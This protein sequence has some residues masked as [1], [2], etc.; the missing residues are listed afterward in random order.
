MRMPNNWNQTPSI[1]RRRGTSRRRKGSV[2]MILN[3]TIL[4]LAALCATIFSMGLILGTRLFG[5]PQANDVGGDSSG[6]GKGG[7]GH[8]AAES[9]PLTAVTSTISPA[10]IQNLIFESAQAEVIEEEEHELEEE[11]RIHGDTKLAAHLRGALV[12]G[13]ANYNPH[14]HVDDVVDDQIAA[15]EG[16]GDRAIYTGNNDDHGEDTGQERQGGNMHNHLIKALKNE[17]EFIVEGEE[18]ILENVAANALQNEKKAAE[19]LKDKVKEVR[20]GFGKVK[21]TAKKTIGGLHGGHREEG[22]IESDSDVPSHPYMTAE[23]K[24][25]IDTEEISGDDESNPPSL[26]DSMRLFHPPQHVEEVDEMRAAL[27]EYSD[28]IVT[29]EEHSNSETKPDGYP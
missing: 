14:H 29:W 10:D 20:E 9:S 12:S 15:G 7:D 2:E 24:G 8:L 26:P 4:V 1:N 28:P 13:D 6:S 23:D 5:S 17:V 19:G 27:Q 11:A 18:R 25:F 22:S 16:G 21:E 3:P